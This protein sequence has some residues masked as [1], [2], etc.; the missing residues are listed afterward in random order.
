MIIIISYEHFSIIT[1]CLYKKLISILLLYFVFH[2]LHHQ[3]NEKEVKIIQT[4][5]QKLHIELQTNFDFSYVI[6]E[7]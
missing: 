4:M 5:I 3:I 2:I 6:Y 1:S 7:Y